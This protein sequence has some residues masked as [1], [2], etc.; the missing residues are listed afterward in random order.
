MATRT[1]IIWL[2]EESI[3]EQ[4]QVWRGSVSQVQSGH[5]VHFPTL[6]ELYRQI[7]LLVEGDRQVPDHQIAEHQVH[8]HTDTAP[9]G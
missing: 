9:C 8:E 6:D 7:G 5:L 1:L 3:D 2:W 4:N